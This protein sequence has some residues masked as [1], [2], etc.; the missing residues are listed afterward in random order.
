MTPPRPQSPND[1]ESIKV[2]ET[3]WQTEWTRP[4]LMRNDVDPATI[5]ASTRLPFLPYL[6]L[7]VV[8]ALNAPLAADDRLQDTLILAPSEGDSWSWLGRD[9][10]PLPFAREGLE[11][12][13]RTAKI[14]SQTASEHGTNRPL[15]LD[16][17]RDGIRARAVYRTVD[18]TWRNE[19][20]P[21]GV[22]RRLYRDSY[23]YESAA[24]ELSR[25]LGLDRVPP[26]VKRRYR[27]HR[28][29]LQAW[30]EN[31]RMEAEIREQ[32]IHPPDTRRWVRQMMR[33]RLFDTLINN[34][35]RNAGNTLID[36]DWEVWLID[37][38]R[39]FLIDPDPERIAAIRQ[40]DRDLLEA[41][42]N[43]DR[44]EVRRRLD[45]YLTPA[46]MKAL[47]TRWDGIVAHFRGLVE[48]FGG[49]FVF[50]SG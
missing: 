30:V 22:W 39:S 38:G 6:V 9:G 19:P 3:S 28:G 27:G 37:H 44:D 5:D 8:L 20:G 26:T 23:I 16:L 35:D 40:T 14:V 24:Y 15:V 43:A 29:S 36:A 42:E 1:V 41:V 31:A 13:L 50:Y 48:T 12:F 21:D 25:I 34:Q 33:R 45:P 11:A 18:I 32:G 17:E 7:L 2:S 49:E 10:E 4:S 46:E 47:F